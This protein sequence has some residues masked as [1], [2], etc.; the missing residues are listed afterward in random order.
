MCAVRVLCSAR[1]TNEQ[2]PNPMQKAKNVVALRSDHGSRGVQ[3]NGFSNAR[4]GSPYGNE[5]TDKNWLESKLANLNAAL[6]QGR[7]LL[8]GGGEGM[9]SHHEELHRNYWTQFDCIRTPLPL[10]ATPQTIGHFVGFV[11]WLRDDVATGRR[12]GDAT[13]RRRTQLALV[14]RRKEPPPPL[15]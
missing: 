13:G 2:W 5:K 8:F 14:P 15:S 3:L 12:R 7:G 6:T 11:S 1:R 10:L 4:G 9:S